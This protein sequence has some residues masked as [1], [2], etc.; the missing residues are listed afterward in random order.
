MHDS[1]YILQLRDLFGM[2]V[3]RVEAALDRNPEIPLEDVK[4]MIDLS[5]QRTAILGGDEADS[6]FFDSAMDSF[7]ELAF[8]EAKQR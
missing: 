5:A 4:K 3:E 8:H 6:A 1:R 2:I 7:V